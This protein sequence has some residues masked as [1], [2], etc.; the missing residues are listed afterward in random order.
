MKVWHLIPD[1]GRQPWRVTSG[2]PVHLRIGTW[3]I[4]AGQGVLVEFHVAPAGGEARSATASARW[5]EHSGEKP[6]GPRRW[7]RS[8]TV[9]V[10]AGAG[11][12]GLAPHWHGLLVPYHAP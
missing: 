5:I 6:T 2:G 11:L 4:E 9:T 3:P 8:P 7:G 10:A 12:V 1:A